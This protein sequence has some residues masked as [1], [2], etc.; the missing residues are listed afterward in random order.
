VKYEGW[1][2]RYKGTRSLVIGAAPKR[3]SAASTPLG[4]SAAPP[5]PRTPNTITSSTLPPSDRNRGQS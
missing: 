2:I 4:K 5:T 3:R 1:K